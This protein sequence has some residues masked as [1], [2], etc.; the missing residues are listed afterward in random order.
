MFQILYGE[1]FHTAG[2]GRRIVLDK[3]KVV[4]STLKAE[5]ESMDE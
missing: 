4:I 3:G 5:K 2:A 1:Q